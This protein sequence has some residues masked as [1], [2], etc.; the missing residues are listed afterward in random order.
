MTILLCTR[1]MD[2]RVVQDGR[3][4][5][6]ACPQCSA[7]PVTALPERCARCDGPH[8]AG[9]PCP[10]PT[11]PESPILRGRIVE[12]STAPPVRFADDDG[13]DGPA[14]TLESDLEHMLNRHCAENPSNTPDWILSQFL[15]GCLTAWN[16][17]VQ[18][19][20]TWYGRD[21]RPGHLHGINAEP[22]TAQESDV[23]RPE[24]PPIVGERM[25]PAPAP[26]DVLDAAEEMLRRIA[27]TACLD[28][29]AIEAAAIVAEL[30][31]LRA[32]VGEKP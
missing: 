31:R 16:T 19:R 25:A 22:V 5:A 17:A 24:V 8:D 4:G 21:A 30:D 3:G 14:P 26:T 11:A 7:E 13:G 28:L 18:Q 6:M 10:G 2:L 23:T 32:L 9:N 1:C 15:I 27:A 12:D 29:D 20:E